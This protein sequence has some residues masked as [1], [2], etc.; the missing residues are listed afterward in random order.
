MVLID[1]LIYY[2]YCQLNSQFYL[3]KVKP[4]EGVVSLY[5]RLNSH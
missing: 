3:I 2:L 5:I 4:T 1:K